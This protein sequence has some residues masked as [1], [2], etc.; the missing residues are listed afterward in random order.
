[1]R[2][3]KTKPRRRVCTPRR[4][5]LGSI[6]E[7]ARRPAS[8]RTAMHGSRFLNARP[9]VKKRRGRSGVRY[10]IFVGWDNSCANGGYR[11]ESAFPAD[12]GST[13]YPRCDSTRCPRSSAGSRHTDNGRSDP[14]PGCCR[15]G[16]KHD[17]RPVVPG[18]SRQ[19]RRLP[20]KQLRPPQNKSGGSW[21]PPRLSLSNARECRLG[22]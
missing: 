13:D 16:P 6:P 22:R 9:A 11:L 10:D 12:I 4:G 2:L 20:K 8:P 14:S 3:H 19:S 7:A 15:R 17:R 18:P 21:N 1:M 5:S